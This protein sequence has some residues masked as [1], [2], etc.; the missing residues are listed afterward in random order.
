MH[1]YTVGDIISVLLKTEAPV[2]YVVQSY[3]I[4]IL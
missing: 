2:S 4:A 1:F 3:E